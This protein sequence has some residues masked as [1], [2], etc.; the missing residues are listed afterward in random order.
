MYTVSTVEFDNQVVP[1]LRRMSNMEKLTL[2]FRVRRSNFIHWWYLSEQLMYSVTC[3]IYIHLSSTSSVT[4]TRLIAHFKPSS[5]DIRRTFIESEHNVDCYID[6]YYKWT[7]S[8]S[9]LFASIHYGTYTLRLHTVFLV[10]CLS[11][12]AFYV[13]VDIVRSFEQDILC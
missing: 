8:M 11:M 1:L 4:C 5:D 12:S 10:V 3:H 6:Y 2:S 9:C 7:R 13:C